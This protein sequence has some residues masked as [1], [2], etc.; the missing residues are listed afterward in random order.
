MP[1][2]SPDLLIDDPDLTDAISPLTVILQ[3]KREAPDT[4]PLSPY[5]QNIWDSFPELRQ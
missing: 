4:E 2:E 5:R 3:F 1:A